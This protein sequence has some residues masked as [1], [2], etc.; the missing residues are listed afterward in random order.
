MHP[1]KRIVLVT[2]LSLGAIGGFT[3]GFARM[4]Q[5][6]S[7]CGAS[8][9]DQFE[10]HIADVCTRSAERVYDQGHAVPPAPPP[11]QGQALAAPPGYA[12]ALVPAAAP[13]VAPIAVPVVAPAA[14]TE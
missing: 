12:W 9:R 6:H 14:P 1:I 11:A 7:A 5:C 8:R 4:A 10:Q 2:L 3:H 13:A